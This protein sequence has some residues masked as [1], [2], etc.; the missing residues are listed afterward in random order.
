MEDNARLRSRPHVPPTSPHNKEG[1]LKGRLKSGKRPAQGPIFGGKKGKT[2][3]WV[4][5]RKNGGLRTKEGSLGNEVK[6]HLKLE[7]RGK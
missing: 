4:V 1:K 5:R 7:V 6:R 2:K 3:N